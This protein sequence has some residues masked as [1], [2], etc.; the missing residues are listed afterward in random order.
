[1]LQTELKPRRLALGLSLQQLADKAGCSRA[2]LHQLEKADAKTT[3]NASAAKLAELEAILNKAST[4]KAMTEAAWQR[5][6]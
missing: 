6:A 4:I 3:R 5:Q 2:Y 1:M